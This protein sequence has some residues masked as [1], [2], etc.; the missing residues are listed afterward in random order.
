MST[1]L[2]LPEAQ[3]LTALE[4][5]IEVGLK[6]FVSVGLALKKIREMQ[7][8][9]DSDRN[10]DEYCQRRW[11]FTKRYGNLLIESA[12]VAKSENTPTAVVGTV[13]AA[14]ALGRVPREQRAE[15]L[16]Q[17]AATTSNHVSGKPAPTA[18]EITA[19]A[20]TPSWKPE[21]FATQPEDIPDDFVCP[22]EMIVFDSIGKLIPSQ[23]RPV[24]QAAEDIGSEMQSVTMLKRSINA[25]MGTAAAAHINTAVVIRDLDN[26]REAL[27]FSLPYA[28]CPLCEST[29]Y[30]QGHR[31]AG[32]RGSGVI[33]ETGYKQLPAEYLT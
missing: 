21:S 31:C 13:S 4:E 19:A 5:V 28:V 25:R 10:F 23:L 7:L 18:S 11:N 20:P 8:Y 24:F 33:T 1:E 9:R 6:S 3:E 22:P 12:G 30:Q 32:C 26:V 17:A 2:T 14:K 29:G 27:K 16:E 15:V